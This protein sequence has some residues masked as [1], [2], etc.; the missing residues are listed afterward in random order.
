MSRV[1]RPDSPSRLRAALLASVQ[2]TL[3][4][5]DTAGSD[6]QLRDRLAF[7]LLALRQVQASIE[8]TAEAWERRAYWVKADQFRRSWA[9]AGTSGDAILKAVEAGD[10]GAACRHALSIQPHLPLSRTAKARDL[11]SVWAGCYQRLKGA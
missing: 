5:L 10:L 6:A 1:I 11:S 9:W 3:P 2:A 7:I 8:P 4:A